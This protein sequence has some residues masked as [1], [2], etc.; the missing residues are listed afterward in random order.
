MLFFGFCIVASVTMA[1]TNVD[2][3]TGSVSADQTICSGTQ[4]NAL[5]IVGFVSGANLQWQHSSDNNIFSDL[6]GKTS[7]LL[8][9]GVL[10]NSAYYRVKVS[11]G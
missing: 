5:S 9:P 3:N 6:S 2:C 4:P 7:P 10:T 1:Q 11:A 8:S